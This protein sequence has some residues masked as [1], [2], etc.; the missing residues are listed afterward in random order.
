MIIIIIIIMAKGRVGLWLEGWKFGVYLLIPIYA[1]YY[2][3]NPD[4]Q[5]KIQDYWKFVQYP[6][7]PNTNLK[8][9]IEEAAK[10]HKQREVYHQQLKLLEQANSKT[11]LEE[12]AEQQQQQQPSRW[13]RLRQW[14]G[15]RGVG[16]NESSPHN[17]E[18]QSST[19]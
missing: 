15:S 13:R 2:F 18:Q 12:H 6:A 9:A 10:L 17:G 16:S 14:F 7:N 8:E 4:N 19:E 3:D 11:P 1:S 5:R